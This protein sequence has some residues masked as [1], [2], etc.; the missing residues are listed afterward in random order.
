MRP[1]LFATFLLVTPLAAQQPAPPAPAPQ[2]SFS[3]DSAAVMQVVG[4]LF[5]GMRKRDTTLMRAQFH[6]GAAMRSA[7]NGRNGMVILADGV[8]DWIHA[9]AGAPDTLLLD[10][11][12]SAPVV[13]VDGNYATV[14]TPYEFWLGN[15]FSHCGAD[16]F[17]FARTTEGWKIVFVADSRRRAGCPSST[18]NTPAPPFTAPSRSVDSAQAV[19]AVLRLLDGMRTRD[20]AQMRSGLEGSVPMYA[21]AQRAEGPALGVDSGSAW[22]TGVAGSINGPTLDE[23]IAS[24]SVE[25]DGNLANVSAYYEFRRGEQFSHCGMDQFVLGRTARG[26]KVIGIGYSAR[27][28]ECTQSLTLDQRASAL[29]DLVAAERAFVRY[30]DSAS[31]PPAF[32]WA[33]RED[34]ITLDGEGVKLMRPIYAAR[35]RNSALLS[36]APSFVDIAADGEMGVTSGPWEWRPAPDSAVKARGQFLTIWR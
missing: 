16:L 3:A 17:S 28:S 26:W 30:A 23:R 22:I 18:P 2:P 11:R 8:G 21:V 13:R 32:V 6:P 27:R 1:S 35:H 34:A 33:L 9:V 19:A 31:A 25:I 29:R 4:D 24:T 15:T 36:W 5:Q 10:E 12:T 20:T 14:W 7:A